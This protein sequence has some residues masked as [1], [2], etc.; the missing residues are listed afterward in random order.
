LTKSLK[1]AIV[2]RYFHKITK[3]QRGQKQGDAMKHSMRSLIVACVIYFLFGMTVGSI[4]G[5]NGV[6]G[7]STELEDGRYELINVVGADPIDQSRT[8]VVVKENNEFNIHRF[9]TM[10][11]ECFNNYNDGDKVLVVINDW[12]YWLRE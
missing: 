9:V 6:E 5:T 4:L 11:P 8:E 7:R 3:S 12:C 10:T 2:L 1:Y